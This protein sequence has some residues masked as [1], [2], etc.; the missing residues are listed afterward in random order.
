MW[1]EW[2]LRQL[3]KLG[4]PRAVTTC[5]RFA[6]D[7]QAGSSFPQEATAGYVLG[8]EG[9]ARGD[10]APVERPLAVDAV[11]LAWHNVGDMLFWLHK[12][13]TGHRE[14]IA[15]LWQRIDGATLIAAGDV[16]FQLS[17]SQWRMQAENDDMDLC[18]LFPAEARRVAMACLDH[19]GILPSAFG[20]P[21]HY[22]ERL[23]AF[24]IKAL[25]SFGDSNSLPILKVYAEIEKFGRAA[26]EAIES[27]QQR[28][29]HG[30]AS[31]HPSGLGAAP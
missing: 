25:G 15:S 29:L 19:E 10:E 27:I 11:H 2:M 17:Q 1:L 20:F 22:D 5:R 12:D 9:C 18:A 4:D 6:M 14:T 16:L 3:I 28:L 23:I 13:R 21:T 8:I 30:A 24:L 26:I 31:A 7:I